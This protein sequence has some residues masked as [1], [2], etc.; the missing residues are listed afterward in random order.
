MICIFVFFSF[1]CVCI[2]FRARAFLGGSRPAYCED[3]LFDTNHP[4]S[5]RT[6]PCSSF[7]TATITHLSS[8]HSTNCLGRS[9]NGLQSTI[10]SCRSSSNDFENNCLPNHCSFSFSS[11]ISRGGSIFSPSITATSNF[12]PFCLN[13]QDRG[14]VATSSQVRFYSAESA[15]KQPEY[16]SHEK[17]VNRDRS[18]KAA[19]VHKPVT[20]LEDL[21]PQKSKSSEVNPLP[22]HSSDNSSEQGTP[23]QSQKDVDIS[24]LEE[25]ARPKGLV[26][27]VIYRYTWYI[28]RLQK[29]LENEMPKTFKMF[30]IFGVGLKTFTSD[31]A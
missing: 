15:P 18:C 29:S 25:Q 28:K 16:E 4:L 17:E 2:N 1:V 27:Y 31:F 11:Q 19:N 23:L 6:V 5:N 7:E 12:S 8:V 14:N 26:G 9:R 30:R 22:D 13:F 24:V 20:I 10:S 3:V 21:N